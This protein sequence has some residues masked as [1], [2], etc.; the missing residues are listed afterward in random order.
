MCPMVNEFYKKPIIKMKM[1][2]RRVVSLIQLNF[3][4][5]DISEFVYVTRTK[6]YQL[7]YNIF[8]RSSFVILVK[9]LS[10]REEQRKYTLLYY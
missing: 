6:L 9:Y 2:K 1:R 5:F 8:A 3:I 10:R 7:T 4:I